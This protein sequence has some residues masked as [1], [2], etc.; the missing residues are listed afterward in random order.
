MQFG[1]LIQFHTVP[2]SYSWASACPH[3]TVHDSCNPD[4]STIWF[5]VLFLSQDTLWFW[6]FPWSDSSCP[7]QSL[8]PL[9]LAA[10]PTYPRD[11]CPTASLYGVPMPDYDTGSD[12]TI[13]SQ[14]CST[15]TCATPCSR[16][17]TCSLCCLGYLNT[18]YSPALTNPF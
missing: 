3:N 1:S 8:N 15:I 12:A 18:C 4:P 11:H 7:S 9:L 10:G 5:L 6:L 17:S 14:V 13:C 16:S 2:R